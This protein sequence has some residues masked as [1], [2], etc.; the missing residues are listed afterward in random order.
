MKTKTLDQVVAMQAKAVRF[1]QDVVG[2]TD[3]ADEIES[4]SPE[5]Y[6]EHKRV[7]IENPAVT[8]RETRRTP[9]AT[10]ATRAELEDRVAELEEEN[11]VLNDKLDSIEEIVGSDE[12][13]DLDD[14]GEDDD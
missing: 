2:D 5:E 9:M 10:K 11:S 12:D 6:A 14:D 7:Q 3:R 8:N 13:E 1:L 4:M